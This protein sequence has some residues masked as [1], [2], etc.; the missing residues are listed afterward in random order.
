MVFANQTFIDASRY[1]LDKDLNKITLRNYN[2]ALNAGQTLSFLY[3]YI[4]NQSNRSLEREDVQHPMIN[5]RGYLYLNRNDL[6][7]LLNNKLYFM[8]INGKKIN[9]DNIM[10]VANNIIR[11]KNDVQTRFNT[12]ILDYTPSIPELAKY[13]DINSDYDIIMNQISNEDINKLFNI[14]NNVTDLEKYIVPDTSQEAIINDIIRTHYTSNGVN[15]GLPFVYT[16]DTSTFKNRS[17]YSLATTVNKYIAPGKYTFT[18]GTEQYTLNYK[19]DTGEI[20]DY[21]MKYGYQDPENPKRIKWRIILN[22]VQDKLDNEAAFMRKEF[23]YGIDTE[24]NAGYGLW[25]MA[26]KNAPTE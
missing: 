10:N 12:L 13:K 2:D 5:E 3:F 20:G 24:D 4:A 14:H 23:R 6:E 8:F 26:Y 17:I 21:E 9:K 11:L 16:Y 22:A 1:V 25:Q 19:T 7:H 15:K 18:F